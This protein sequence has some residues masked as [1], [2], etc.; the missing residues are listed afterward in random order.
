MLLGHLNAFLEVARLGTV[1]GASAVLHVGQPALSA[2]IGALEAEIGVQLFERRAR[3]M[4]LTAAGRALL[5]HVERAIASIETGIGHARHV[6]GDAEHQIVLGAAP[7]V[8]AYVLPELV[9]RLRVARPGLRVLVRT[10]HS[11]EIVELIAAGDVGLGLIRD[12]RDRRIVAWPIYEEELVLVVRADHPFAY[13]GRV[14]VGRLRE[15]VLILFDRTSTYYDTTA[16]LFRSA[17]VAPAGTMEVDNIE[18]AKRMT[19]RGL[20]ISFLPTTAIADAVSEGSFVA[21]QV[22]GL[23]T[24]RRRVIAAQRAGAPPVHSDLARLLGEIPAMIPGARRVALEE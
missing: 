14:D 6:D 23:P 21:V 9:A 18:T 16:S 5:P 17:G 2:R 24:V 4:V 7:A 13:E 10:G 11:E 8:S 19:S 15:S 1:R 20:G 3:G 12:L 22:V